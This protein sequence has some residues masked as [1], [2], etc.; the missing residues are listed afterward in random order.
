MEICSFVSLSLVLVLPF[1]F[2]ERVFYSPDYPGTHH[3]AQT[4]LKLTIH[5]PWF[6]KWCNASQACSIG[7]LMRIVL[8]YILLCVVTGIIPVLSSPIHKH[9]VFFIY[10]SIF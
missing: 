8:C 7:I 9:W 10:L 5:L 4:D 3:E 2:G 1:L 6:P